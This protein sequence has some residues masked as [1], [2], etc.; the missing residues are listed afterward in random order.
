MNSSGKHQ[1]RCWAATYLL[2][3]RADGF[4]D[5]IRF[6][7]DTWFL[8]IDGT[9]LWCG[10]SVRRALM[11]FYR[12]NWPRSRGWQRENRGI[13]E[14]VSLRRHVD[15]VLAG[16]SLLSF[17]NLA[18]RL[19]SRVAV[20]PAGCGYG[21]ANAKALEKVQQILDSQE[22]RL[23]AALNMLDAAAPARM[24]LRPL[25][26]E[27]HDEGDGCGCW[28][29]GQGCQLLES[30]QPFTTKVGVVV[31]GVAGWLTMSSI[32]VANFWKV[33]NPET[34][35]I[36]PAVTT[37]AHPGARHLPPAHRTGP[38]RPARSTRAPRHPPAAQPA[39]PPWAR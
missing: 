16:V 17:G 30:W 22:V 23:P 1:Q 3:R 12:R 6:T 24:A 18:R 10:E 5:V 4:G 27:A 34:L 35:L 11:Q 26:P 25:T 32:R 28:R 19:S 15:R 21:G 8:W 39:S 9:G 38:G 36:T 31:A 33:G 37:A 2:S 7:P 29:R 14:E 13:W 20:S